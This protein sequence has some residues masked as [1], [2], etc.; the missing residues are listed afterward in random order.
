MRYYY[1]Q[2]QE[3]E[4]LKSIVILIDTR[5]QENDHIIKWFEA[6][7]IPYKSK[8]LDFGDYSFFIPANKELDIPRDLMFNDEIVIERKNSLD[9]VASNLSEKDGG[10]R[11]EA[12][13]IRAQK[14]KAIFDIVIEDGSWLKLFSGDY[15]SEYKPKSFMARLHAFIARYGVSINFIDKILMAQ[16]IYYRFYYYARERFGKVL[17]DDLIE[18]INEDGKEL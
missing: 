17:M 1:T 11:F 5:E 4:L 12:E 15:R 18:T 13:L 6:K 8:K 16:H 2:K 3:K 14:A 7:R 10:H 9:E